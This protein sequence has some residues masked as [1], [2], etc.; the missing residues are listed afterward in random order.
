[1]SEVSTPKTSS[2][3]ETQYFAAMDAKDAVATL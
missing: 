1:M 3:T 2:S